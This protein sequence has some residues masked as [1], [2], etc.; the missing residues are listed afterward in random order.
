MGWGTGLKQEIIERLVREVVSLRS[1]VENLERSEYAAR[2]SDADTVDGRHATDFITVIALR[3]TSGTLHS[4]TNTAFTDI[5]DV[6]VN[7]SVRAND[8][9]FAICHLMGGSSTTG[10]SVA[11]YRLAISTDYSQP[12]AITETTANAPIPVALTHVVT[13]SATA[14]WEVRVQFA[15]ASGATARSQNEELVVLRI[16]PTP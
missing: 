9:V 16:R 3:S 11:R 6:V 8:V 15:S 4:T 5:P 2:A 1:R 10:A 12:L 14:T 7:V 13:A